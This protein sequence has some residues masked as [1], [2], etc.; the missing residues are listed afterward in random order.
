MEDWQ[1]PSFQERVRLLR[2]ALS[3]E[4]AHYLMGATGGMPNASTPLVWYFVSRV[5]MFPN[6]F[7][8]RRPVLH[9]ARV[10]LRGGDSICAGRSHLYAD[11]RGP[12]RPRVNPVPASAQELGRLNPAE[13]LWPRPAQNVR[14][15]MVYG[16][17]C[18]GKRH[19]DCVHFVN[20]CV[21]TLQGR[22]VQHSIERWLEHS[23][24]VW[25]GPPDP[26]VRRLGAG[27]E[28]IWAGDIEISRGFGHIGLLTG[29]AVDPTN[30]MLH[31]Q[32]T[33][34]G[35]VRSPFRVNEEQ[36]RSRGDTFVRRLN[37]FLRAD[38]AL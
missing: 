13:F 35:V 29:G 17:A 31:A 11:G 12:H 23:R 26:A 24:H 15:E 19:F 38:G 3:Q 6:H 27:A 1:S 18:M 25:P 22:A 21:S 7:D 30:H 9:A 36:A 5:E 10:Q 16:E 37:I 28:R 32:D 14:G 20:W 34:V 33:R 8:R 2:L 4:G